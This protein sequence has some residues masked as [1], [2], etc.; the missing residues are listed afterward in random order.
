M[1]ENNNNN[2]SV[3]INVNDNQNRYLNDY[4]NLYTRWLVSIEKRYFPKWTI[5]AADFL[6][7]PPKIGGMGEMT[8]SNQ[9]T[10]HWNYEL[11]IN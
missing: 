5:S 11:I 8:R 2:G 7:K 10:Y 1:T 6:S 4:N 9:P 3:S